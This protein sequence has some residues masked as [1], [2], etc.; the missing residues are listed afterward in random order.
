MSSDAKNSNSSD[1]KIQEKD[2][3][4]NGRWWVYF[5][6]HLA[7]ISVVYLRSDIDWVKFRCGKLGR[8]EIYQVSVGAMKVNV[9]NQKNDRRLSKNYRPGKH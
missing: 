7:Q 5:G 9:I 1:E 4:L 8:S 2:E 6:T 3:I